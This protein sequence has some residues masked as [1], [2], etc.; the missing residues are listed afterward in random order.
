M[1]WWIL[2]QLRA[3]LLSDLRDFIPEGYFESKRNEFVLHDSIANAKHFSNE[4]RWG[5]L[6]GTLGKKL[7]FEDS[8]A[9][10]ARQISASEV[11]MNLGMLTA[12]EAMH[13]STNQLAMQ[14]QMAEISDGNA[15][16]V[17]N[18]LEKEHIPI[19]RDIVKQSL[20]Q[21]LLYLN[22]TEQSP[23][24]SLLIDDQVK[25]SPDHQS[26]D[27]LF[28]GKNLDQNEGATDSS[29]V[30]NIENH[31]FDVALSFPGEDREL[32][33]NVAKALDSLIGRHSYFYDFHYQSQLA[34][35]SLDTLLQNIYRNQST[36]IVVFLSSGYQE[37][38]WCNIEFRA[39][40]EIILDKEFKQIMFIRT[41]DGA[42]DGIF[43]TDGYIDANKFSS[44]EIADFIHERV[45]VLLSEKISIKQM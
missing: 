15:G 6:A 39:I 10:S 20:K 43:K 32:V 16:I 1:D 18:Q 14:A 44:K 45:L 7:F 21:Y 30:I 38:K 11:L 35:P 8:S 2:K 3:M 12:T 23:F 4:L 22:Q 36:L 26:N 5:Y 24:N 17:A 31:H 13:G 40:R 25:D 34:R 42:V 29:N 9:L 33:R 28:S 27:R 37:K 41:D 19:L